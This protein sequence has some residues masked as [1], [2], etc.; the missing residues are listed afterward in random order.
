MN[1]A[2]E[3]LKKLKVENLE[4]H[5]FLCADQTEPKCVSKDEGLRSWEYLKKRLS[6]LGLVQSGKVFRTKANCLRVCKEGPIMCIYPQ[7]RWFKQCTP[8]VIEMVIQNYIL[9]K[10]EEELKD[11][12]IY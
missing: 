6:E 10:N 9:K 4:Y 2:K 7:G 12:I 3:I 11:Y 1:E 5:I 8:E